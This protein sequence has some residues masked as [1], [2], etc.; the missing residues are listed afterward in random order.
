MPYG[1]SLLGDCNGIHHKSWKIFRRPIEQNTIYGR[2]TEPI[3]MPA[4]AR[5]GKSVSAR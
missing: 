3:S 4:N 1:D 5:G 2:S